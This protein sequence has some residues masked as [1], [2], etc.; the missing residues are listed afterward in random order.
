MTFAG[1]F[2]G[3]RRVEWLAA[4]VMVAIGVHAV[5]V[6]GAFATSRMAP[7]LDVIPFRVFC[8]VY[9][10]AGAVRLIGLYFNLGWWG[11]QMRAGG[12][13]LGLLGSLQMGWALM[14]SCVEA[15]IPVSTQ[16]W[17][18]ILFAYHEGRSIKRA[19]DD[20]Q[21]IANGASDAIAT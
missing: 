19:T 1:P 9:I 18:Y 16:I 7:V 17:V 5:I 4:Q 13:F 20:A 3:A 12:S 14:V 8:A 11:A 10:A 6:P 21:S 2:Y 15:G